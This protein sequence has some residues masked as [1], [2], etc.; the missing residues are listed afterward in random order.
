MISGRA[1]RIKVAEEGYISTNYNGSYRTQLGHSRSG[2][3]VELRC[4]GIQ[5]ITGPLKKHL[6]QEIH[7]E[8]RDAELGFDA[9]LRSTLGGGTGEPAGRTAGH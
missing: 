7:K 1:G 9:P 2:R 4:Q 8:L 6:L 5:E 3:K